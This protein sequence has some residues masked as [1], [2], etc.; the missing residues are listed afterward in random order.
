MQLERTRFGSRL[1]FKFVTKSLGII[2]QRC[3]F[4]E[5]TRY[6]IEEVTENLRRKKPMIF[7][8]P[9]IDFL[10]DVFNNF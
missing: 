5:K 10:E 2:V 9:S 3:K 4:H 6:D 7:L 1:N 8:F